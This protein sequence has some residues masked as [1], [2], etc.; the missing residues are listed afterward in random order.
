MDKIK[1]LI[2]ETFLKGEEYGVKAY[3]S[4]RKEEAITKATDLL[5]EAEGAFDLGNYEKADTAIRLA[6]ALI[7][8]AGLL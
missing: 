4:T 2:D 5:I 8:L 7:K 1:E 6:E 3:R